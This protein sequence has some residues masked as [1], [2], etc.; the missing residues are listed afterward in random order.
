MPGQGTGQHRDPGERRAD[1]VVSDCL[2]KSADRTSV[3]LVILS[4][5]R[6]GFKVGY[7]W[8][9]MGGRLSEVYGKPDQGHHTVQIEINRSLYMSEVTKQWRPELAPLLEKKL[10]SAISAIVSGLDQ[11]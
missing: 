3:D 8:P 6:A 7:N 9:Y 11:L 2:G 4:F 1:I 5:V 10:E